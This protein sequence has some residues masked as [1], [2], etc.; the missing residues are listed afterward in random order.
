MDAKA[1]YNNSTNSVNFSV[2]QYA[3][4]A[5]GLTTPMAWQSWANHAF[6]ITGDIN[7]PLSDMPAMLRRRAS[8]AGK[9]A[10]EVAYQCLALSS[11]SNSPVIFCSRHGE[12][13]RSVELLM[14][15]AQVVPISPITFSL[16]VHNAT[17]GLFSISQ[18][19]HHN[20]LALAAGRSTV[21]HAVIEA[22][23]LLADGHDQILIVAYDNCLP[24]VFSEFNDCEE[25]AFAWAWLVTPPTDDYMSLSWLAADKHQFADEITSEQPAGLNILRF[26][27]RKDVVLQRH[28]DGRNW[29]WK[30]H[31]KTD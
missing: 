14:D 11:N 26:F 29:Q 28:S 9:M 31:D 1:D 24:E 4:W 5:P 19:H 23:G 18:Q 25:Q 16:S 21:E 12:C 27:L 20:I 7:P 30:R 10:L 15:L 13:A 17:A 6:S 8:A 3:A 22:C 2:A